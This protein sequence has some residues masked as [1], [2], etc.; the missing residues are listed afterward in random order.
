LSNPLKRSPAALLL[1]ALLL[2]ALPAFAQ[3]MPPQEAPTSPAT[4]AGASLDPLIYEKVQGVIRYG[5]DGRGTKETIACVRVQT[6]VGVQKIGQL[7][8][9]YNGANERVEVKSVRVIK[10][11]G[12]QVT[13]GS[14]A[15]ID[16]SSPVVQEAPMYTD[17]RQKH[18]SV[19]GLS[20]GDIVE[21]DVVTRVFEPLTPGQFW[22]SWDFTVHSVCLDDELVLD[23]PANRSLKI[24]YPDGIEPVVT[25][26]AGRRRYSWRT[27][28]KKAFDEPN[29][30]G[31]S[32]S[33]DPAHILKGLAEPTLRRV[34]FSTFQ[35][36]D[37]VAQ[38]YGAL[39]QDRQTPSPEVHAKAVEITKDAATDLAKVQ[40]LYDY[41]SHIRYV[42]LSFGVGRYQPH[43]A[44][45]VLS[46]RYGDCKDKATLLDALLAAEGIQSAT[47]LVQTRMDVDRDLPTPMQFDHAINVVSLGGKEIWLDSAIGVEPFAYL[48]P[49]LRGKDA[50]VVAY[51]QKSE[52]RQAPANLIG[53]KTYR[54]TVEK[55]IDEKG[56]EE[57]NVAVEVQGGDWEVLLRLLLSRLTPAQFGQTLSGDP[58]LGG[59]YSGGYS[60]VQAGDPFDT[61][62]PFW[63]AAHYSRSPDPSV[64]PKVSTA[65]KKTPSPLAQGLLEKMLPIVGIVFAGNKPPVQ[66]DGPKDFYL[67][68]KVTRKSASATNPPKPLQLTKDFGDYSLESSADHDTITVDA[69]LSLRER[70]LDGSRVEEYM[71][72]RKSVVES[73][74]E[75]PAV[76][77]NTAAATKATPPPSANSSSSAD[78]SKQPESPAQALYVAA[79]KASS[80]R[81]YSACAQLLEQAVALDPASDYAWNFLGWTYNSL[82]KYEKAESALRKA[83]ALNPLGTGANNN[84]GQALAGQKKYEEAIPQFRKQI[85]INPRDQWAHEN[86]GRMYL[87]LEQ[88]EKAIPELEIAASIKPD[89]PYIPYNLGRAYAKTGQPEK[90]AQSFKRSVD[91]QPVPSRFNSVAYEMALNKLDLVQARKYAESAIAAIVV[92]MRGVSLDHVTNED[93]RLTASLAAFWDTFGWIRFQQGNLPDAEKYVQGAWLV[94]STGEVGD[95]LAQIYEKQ[96]RKEEAIHQYELSL[97]AAHPTPETRGRLASLLGSDTDID[98]LTEQAKPQLKEARTIQ[99]KNS[100]AAEGIAEFWVLL[101]PGPTV[102][103]AKFVTGDDELTQFSK[104]I[105]AATFPD[106]FP[107]ATEAQLLRRARLSC[108]PSAPNC[109][110]LLMSA[111][112]V[113]PAELSGFGSDSEPAPK[114]INLHGQFVAPPKI[115][116]RVEP[117][118]PALARQTGIQGT[119]KLHAILATDGSVKQLQVVSGHP[120]LVQ[121]AMDAA[122]QWKY[123]PTILNGQPVEVETEIDVIFQLTGSK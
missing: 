62:K 94:H 61:T 76:P 69:H 78:S 23:V 99:I 10:P 46:N 68:L 3:E 109:S 117:T 11:D 106:C 89:S 105:E 28:N 103:G 9:P 59:G 86:L 4:P 21:Y 110:L 1:F 48:L 47:A 38:W 40:A 2:P 26:Q 120:L 5:D 87:L 54:F 18:V 43:S 19:P 32:Q 14:E 37:E 74:L 39:S 34:L 42:S 101:S 64:D 13:A 49:Q 6:Y 8:F 53:A 100:H 44:L 95:H 97:A 63:L 24:K 73:L 17:A 27:E 81:D 52:L 98:H 51:P 20:V 79:R 113:Q 45:D 58:K 83:I 82:G 93:V 123:E 119:V 115:K 72:F 112:A 29:P 30:F 55:S 92:Q 66:L 114:R 107:E 57:A 88:Y 71:A 104:D 75:P 80:T 111:E 33:L 7:I 12:T 91:I 16:V 102:R 25:D 35:S 15:V 116:S 84:L 67:S 96:G 36:W 122:R 65:F 22:D 85:E 121:A 118:Y 50:L 56:A 90:A 31:N 60:N 41:V 70:E 108:P 77:V